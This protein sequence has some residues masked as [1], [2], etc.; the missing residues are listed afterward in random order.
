[1]SK[2]TAQARLLANVRST[3]VGDGTRRVVMPNSRGN[4]DNDSTSVS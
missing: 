2:G 3:S 1:M 4:S